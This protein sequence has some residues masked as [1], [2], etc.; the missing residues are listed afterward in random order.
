MGE[1]YNKLRELEKLLGVR[2]RS[3]REGIEGRKKSKISSSG[4]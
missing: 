2:D 4:A 1:G 3:K